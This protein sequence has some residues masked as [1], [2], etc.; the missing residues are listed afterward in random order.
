MITNLVV[1]CVLM[2]STPQGDICIKPDGNVTFPEG[3]AL[4]RVSRQFWNELAK[5][6]QIVKKDWCM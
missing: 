4:D 3:V 5:M 1:T 2:V 6:F